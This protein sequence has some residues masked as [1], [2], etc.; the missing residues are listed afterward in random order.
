MQIGIFSDCHLGENLFRKIIDGRNAWSYLAELSMRQAI[1]ALCDKGV[2]C[3]IIAGDLFDLPNPDIGSLLAAK[4]AFEAVNVPIFLLGGNHEWSQ[5]QKLANIHPFDLLQNVNTAYDSPKQ[6][7]IGDKKI[8][9]LPY[10]SLTPEGFEFARLNKSDILVAHGILGGQEQIYCIPE[11]IVT[12]YE[13]VILGHVHTSSLVKAGKT[14]I[15]TPGSTMP[16]NTFQTTPSVW[17]Y[18][19]DTHFIESVPLDVPTMHEV[20]IEKDKIND[21]LE[22]ILENPKSYDMYSIHYSGPASDIDELTYKRCCGHTLNIRLST[23]ENL[24]ANNGQKVEDFWVTV[25]DLHPEWVDEF[26]SILH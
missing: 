2:D 22:Q 1:N 5:R 23:N 14:T 17:I 20:F 9:M 16:P 3:I 15:L 26:K 6:F 24:N 4:A 21:F 25:Q 8:M 7:Q 19:T 12:N 18:N 10:K 11:Q 13:L